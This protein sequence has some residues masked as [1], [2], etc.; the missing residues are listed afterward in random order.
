MTTEDPKPPEEKPAPRTA[1][2]APGSITRLDDP[3]LD[4]EPRYALVVGDG[5]VSPL[6]VQRHEL[7][8]HKA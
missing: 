2:P 1:K 7:P 4:G 5:L 6:A 3:K 8:T